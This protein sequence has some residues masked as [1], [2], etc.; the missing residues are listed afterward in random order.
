MLMFFIIFTCH[1]ALHL[2]RSQELVE[3]V[4]RKVLHFLL[5]IILIHSTNT[6]NLC[7]YKKTFNQWMLVSK[8]HLCF[9]T[10]IQKD[11][12]LLSS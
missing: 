1:V 2:N 10:I 8:L 5:F 3:K 6:K 12:K 7:F 9:I 11:Y 4:E